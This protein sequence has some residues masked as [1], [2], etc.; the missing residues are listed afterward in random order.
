MASYLLLSVRL[1]CIWRLERGDQ[2]MLDQ[3]IVVKA[4][5]GMKAV[6]EAGWTAGLE[7]G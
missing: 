7:P 6:N 2:A 5:G 4:M 3:L 1:P